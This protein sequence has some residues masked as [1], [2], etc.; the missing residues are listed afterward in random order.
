MCCYAD[1]LSLEV[2]GTTYSVSFKM[3]NN[4]FEIVTL[5]QQCYHREQNIG[6]VDN[7]ENYGPEQSCLILKSFSFLHNIVLSLIFPVHIWAYTKYKKG[8]L[9][10]LLDL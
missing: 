7:N 5:K 1:V 9:C 3:Q 10:D 6:S 8:A 4:S 2:K